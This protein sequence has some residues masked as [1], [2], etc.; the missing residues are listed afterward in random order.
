M[1]TA[2]AGSPSA[3]RACKAISQSSSNGCTSAA[4]GFM[5][6]TTTVV[7][8]QDACISG[9]LGLVQHCKSAR[10]RLDAAVQRTRP[11]S[12]ASPSPWVPWRSSSSSN[13]CTSATSPRCSECLRRTAYPL[14]AV[15]VHLGCSIV[16]VAQVVELGAASTTSVTQ[17]IHLACEGGHLAITQWLREQGADIDAG[18]TMATP[19][20]QTTAMRR[21]V[22]P[23][24]GVTSRVSS[25]STGCVGA[26]PWWRSRQR[27]GDGVCEGVHDGG[28]RAALCGVWARFLRFAAQ[29]CFRSRV[30]CRAV[31]ARV[32]SACDT[33]CPRRSA[34]SDAPTRRRIIRFIAALAGPSAKWHEGGCGAVNKRS[35]R[36]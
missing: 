17:P 1:D 7:S 22:L 18:S 33:R 9:V 24:C 21:F 34:S 27:M 5:R 11:V 26:V 19:A 23:L 6:W 16:L 12:R 8:R 36:V 28:Q 4:W 30:I 14:R 31:R 2:R 29:T 20:C 10:R 3:T 35:W 15:D 25:G 32:L 13:G